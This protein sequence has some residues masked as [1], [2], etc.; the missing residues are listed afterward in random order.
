MRKIPPR[1]ADNKT[2]PAQ[3]GHDTKGLPAA[4]LPLAFDDKMAW[5]KPYTD[6]NHDL[7]VRPFCLG[8]RERAC[9]FYFNGVIDSDILND[10]VLK[11]LMLFGNGDS[12]DIGLGGGID[13][14]IRTSINVGQVRTTESFAEMAQG[15]FDGMLILIF[16]NVP[17]AVIINIRGG[18]VRPLEEPPAEKVTHGPR[19]GFIENLDINISMVRRRLRNPRLVI[20]K[21]LVGRRTRTPVAVLY[22]DDI[23]DQR[24]IDEVNY[25]LG[26]IDVDGIMYTGDIIQYIE[27]QPFSPFPQFWASE[28]PDKAIAELL[29]GRIAIMVD[30][31]PTVLFLPSL[32]IEFFQA[33]EDYSERTFVSSYL[34]LLRFLAYFLAISL[35]AIYISLVSFSPELLPL[36]LLMSLAQARKEVPFPVLV[37]VLIQEFIIQIVIE[38]G[39]RLPG[40]VGQTVGVV[41]GIVLGQAATSA[42]LASP[43]IIIIIAITAICTFT[44]PAGPLVQSTRVLR[45]LLIFI[46][47]IFGLFGFSLGWLLILAHLCSLESLGNPYFAPFVPLQTGDL[48][49]SFYR[50][51]LWKMDLRPQSIPVQQKRRRNMA[52]KEG[53]EKNDPQ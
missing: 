48:K 1:S 5:L 18:Q 43:A 28:R 3:N 10:H 50:T 51:W 29:E 41:A 46:T 6:K 22:I 24:L 20:K 14:I 2:A 8:A 45:L 49:D 15:I 35:P 17:E 4:P 39:L 26:Q 7:I 34:R 23:A 52:G 44:L 36:D 37:E 33:P 38:S 40:S 31:T 42:K 11:P 16:E 21:T 13:Y 9:A 19:E 25:R 30:G 47:S 32:F 27:D 53:G 12:N